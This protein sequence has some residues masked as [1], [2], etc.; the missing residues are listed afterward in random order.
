MLNEWGLMHARLPA[1]ST[2]PKAV[3]ALN[4]LWVLHA[5]VLK[6]FGY[7]LGAQTNFDKATGTCIVNGAHDAK[8]VSACRNWPVV[9]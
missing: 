2:R 5:D 6:Y 8:K 7:E 3:R 9:A 4:T 1:G